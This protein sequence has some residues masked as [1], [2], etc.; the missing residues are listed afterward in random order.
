MK[1]IIILTLII[2][3]IAFALSG[4]S[5]LRKPK[6]AYVEVNKIIEKYA[7]AQKA[8]AEL[9]SIK[10]SIEAEHK[11]IIDSLESMKSRASTVKSPKELGELQKNFIQL[12]AQENEYKK[13][14]QKRLTEAEQKRMGPVLAKINDFIYNYGKENGYIFIFGAVGNGSMMFADTAYDITEEVIA[15]INGK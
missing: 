2:S 9:D 8:K 4:Y 15:A 10:G 7:F 5:L 12:K 1:K 11:Q 13:V 3:T 6:Y 14:S